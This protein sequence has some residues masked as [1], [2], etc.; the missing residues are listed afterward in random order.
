MFTS[1]L[2][3]ADREAARLA[4]LRE[5]VVLDSAPEPLFDSIARM[6][7]EVC[8]APIALL[9]LVDDQRQ[10]FKANVGLP[11]VNETPRDIA[12]CA[13]AIHSDDLFEVP[14]ATLDA[15]FADN[16]LV[17]GPTH[18]RFY[19][20]AP[21]V[22]PQGE[23]VGTLC[24]ID[25]HARGITSLQREKLQEL[26]ALTT[27]ALLMRQ[28]LIEKTL[29]VRSDYE[30]ALARSEE[31]Y[32]AL[33]EQQAELVSLA[34][35]DGTLAY[36]NSAY[37]R[38]FG[39]TAD[40]MIGKNLLDF[41]SAADQPVV[42][43]RIAAVLADGATRIGENRM[44]S[45]DGTQRWLEWTNTLQ[46]DAR[47]T[48]LLHS[49]GRDITERKLVEQALRTSES[50]LLRTG[51]VAGVG[52]WE[53]D[54]DDGT[55]IWSAQTR[56]IHE[57]ADDFVPTVETGI[58]FYAPTARPLIEAAVK[59][60]L[61]CG[62]PW[63]LELPFVTATGRNIWVRAAG[64]VE[65]ENGRPRRLVGA[66]QDITERKLL[67]QR[68]ADSERFTRHVTDH[69]PVRIAYVDHQRR[70]RFANRQHC[71]TFGLARDQIIGKTRDELTS[72]PDNALIIRRIDAA[73]SGRRQS[74]EFEDVVAGEKRLI[75]G[76]LLPDFDESGQVAGYFSIGLDITERAA[77]ERAARELTAIFES[78]TDYV[79]QVDPDGR[80]TYL[81]PAIRRA[82][83]L[84]PGAP[85]SPLH[86][87]DFLTPET[88]HDFAQVV[89]PTL[90]A[91]QVWVGETSVVLDGRSAVPVAQMVIA[92]RDAQNR[93]VRF[94]AVMRD[95]TA[96]TAAKL[97]AARQMA[98]LRSVTDAIPSSVAVYG[99]DGR[100]QFVNRAFEQWCALPRERII[101]Q[102]ASVVLGAHEFERRRPWI[103]RAAKGET[104]SFE[105]EYPGRPATHSMISYF[106]LLPETGALQGIVV[107]SQ[108]VTQ[109][110]TERR[111]LLELSQQDALTGLLNR[112]GF[113]A[114]LQRHAAHGGETSLAVLYIDMDHFKPVND[115]HG[116]PTGDR[117]LQLFAK[118][119][120]NIV[121]PADAVARLGGDE[122][123]VALFGVG[124][125][126]HA[127]SVAKKVL[128]AAS[129]PFQTDGLL[130][131]L[132]A[133]IGVAFACGASTDMTRLV[134]QA[135]AQLLKAKAAG[136]GRLA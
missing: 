84:T 109:Q 102:Q 123:A 64:E 103:E 97:E 32:R 95:I 33:V 112:S 99:A 119:L 110:T 113:D 57:V 87:A 74:F 61:S 49:V 132:G 23:R 52:G 44:R 67:E 71:E 114:A 83:S 120:K 53:L 22:L 126:A 14:D 36:L 1:T 118:R 59:A 18:I 54:L 131:N 129:T 104:V 19:A 58:E 125:E 51:R 80:I 41:V 34:G 91:G 10:W 55:L 92:H 96:A 79:A 122:F 48:R 77:A 39:I 81:N 85:V 121:R 21:L 82:G 31:K 70:Y 116:H 117:V 15:R 45:A 78:T 46:V 89:M 101:G 111:R 25:R 93:I 7:S 108:D 29:Q 133:S 56:R 16:P 115:R 2:T 47:G 11:G 68:L 134:A 30:Q 128:Q 105:L 100:Y 63:D 4:R 3:Q 50:L 127:L 62:T 94:S 65:T 130:L 40:Q 9:S 98:I 35:P 42:R 28:Q 106:P 38:H 107:V 90:K 6:A 75:E 60:A 13:H 20:G 72:G 37:A 43:A 73:L 8:G 135:D 76:Q 69:L 124:E 66:F 86:Y 5:L 136:K 26:A 17:T 88:K 27:Q 12:F 24:V